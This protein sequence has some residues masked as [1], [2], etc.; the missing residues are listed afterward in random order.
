[1]SLLKN[2]NLHQ[3][4]YVSISPGSHKA[5]LILFLKGSQFEVAFFSPKSGSIS[6]A[7]LY[8]LIGKHV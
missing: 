5:L 3:V 7:A 6:I 1:M 4:S 2:I 8:K